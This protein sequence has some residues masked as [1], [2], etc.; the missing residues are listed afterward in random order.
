[1][2]THTRLRGGTG[3]YRQFPDLD[4]VYGIHGGGQG[5]QPER[6]LH[7]D[8]GVEH[9]LPRQTR[10]LFNVYTRSERDVLWTPG[11]ETRLTPTGTI[12]PGSFNAPWVNAL[13]GEARGA[14]VVVRRDAPDGFSGW[15]GYAFGRLRYTDTR[16]GES[17]WADADQ[18]HTLTL[19][20]NYRLSS[21]ASVSVRYRYGSNYP[22]IGYIGEPSASLGQNPVD[23]G[24]PLFFELTDQRNTLRLPVYSRLDVRADR[25]FNWSGRRIVL[26]VDVA[27]V[28][29][30]TN[31]RNANYFVD[32]AGRVFDTMESLMPI[33]PS[34]GFVI[35]F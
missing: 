28:L 24:R 8:A 32:R 4:A 9:T 14:E 1:L 27:N 33:V 10:I 17:F 3:I 13:R 18:R 2:S 35:E 34:G 25:A 7:V 15:A 16:T 23:D 31:V 11:S 20:G 29:N 5:L 26:F 30:R 6:A 19:Y 22:V 12:S 21:R